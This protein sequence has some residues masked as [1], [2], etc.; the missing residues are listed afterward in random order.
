MLLGKKQSELSA[1]KWKP[2]WVTWKTTT[3]ADK[4]MNQLDFMY[5]KQSSVNRW[6]SFSCYTIYVLDDISLSGYSEI[7]V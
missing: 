2:T 6:F 7:Q 4:P 3:E 1:V 5:V